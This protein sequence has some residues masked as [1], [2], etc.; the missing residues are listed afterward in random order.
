MY[1]SYRAESD[2]PLAKLLFDE[3]IHGKTPGGHRVTVDSDSC[4]GHAQGAEWDADIA[5]GLLHSTCCVP[6]LSL[7]ATAP[8][9]RF[10]EG[11]SAQL[12]AAGWEEAPL[13]LARLG[14]PGQDREDA[15]LKEML[16]A[17]ALLGRASD[18]GVLLSGERGQLLAAV[19]VFAGRQHPQGHPEYP[20]MGD[21]SDVHGGGGSFSTLPSPS[22]GQAAARFL[23]DRAGLPVEV[24]NGFEARSVASVVTGL[25]NLQGCRLWNQAGD[26]REAVL[27]R[28]Q[29]GL[30]GK[31]YAGPAV[32]LDD[33]ILSTE[34]V[35]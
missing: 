6:I 20:R 13:G 35:T 10:A 1:L 31:G 22:T 24:A 25:A 33:N 34:Q 28:E 21:Y 11:A 26:V 29:E 7:V 4:G 14:G 12:A 2:G 3:L 5:R 8:M 16:I 18:S 15:L 27:T 23:L 19:P 9:A 32:N 30:V 17:D